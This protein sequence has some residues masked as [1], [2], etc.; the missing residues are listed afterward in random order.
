MDRRTWWIAARLA[1]A[2]AVVYVPG[3]A[4]RAS[5]PVASPPAASP[6]KRFPPAAAASLDV[7]VSDAAGKPVEGAF[8]MAVPSV[9]GYGRWGVLVADR[10]R[11]T[12]TSREGRA[13]LESLPAG[14][15]RVTVHARGYVEKSLPRV[16]AGPLVVRVERGGVITGSVRT[17]D[18]GRPIAGARVR[19]GGGPPLP[20]AWQESATR[21][22]STTDAQGR[23]RLEGIGRSPVGIVA[24]AAGFGSA[25]R[26]DVR[27]GD[28]VD[29]FLFPGA[30]LRGTVRDDAGRPVAAAQ[31]YAD[32]DR[33]R[34]QSQVET[35]DA[36]GAFVMAGIRPGEYV[37]VARGGSRAPG[38]AFV[39]VE[40]DAEASVSL[41]LSEGG[42]ATGQ[43]VDPDGRPLGGRVRLEVFEERGLSP[44]ASDAISS[45][46]GADGRFAL[47][48]LPLGTLGIGVSAPRHAARRV[49]VAIPARGR[50]VDLGRVTLETG[51]VIRGS[52]RDREGNPVLGARVSASSMGRVERSMG[53]AVT[54]S[55]AAFV[56]AGLRAGPHELIA[57]AAGFATAR[58]RGEPGGAPVTLVLQPGGEI[59]GRVVDA[60]GD[61]VDDADVESQATDDPRWGP[62]GT[63]GRSDEG[64]GRFAL[65]DV[66]AGTYVLQVRASGRGEASVTAVRVEPGRPT[67]VGT[68]VLNRGGVVQGVVVDV[69]GQGVVGATIQLEKDLEMQAGRYET[70]TAVS[71][72]F[73]LR[74]VPPGKIHVLA[75]HPAFA[76]VK[77]VVAD[78]DPEK[79]PVPVRIVLARGAR[80]EG[81]AQRRDGSPFTG[82]RITVSNFEL[83]PAMGWDP[84]AIAADGSFAVD[85]IA[86]GPATVNLMAFTPTSAMASGPTANALT[87]IATQDVELREGETT[88]ASF[89]LRDVIVAGHVTR[90]GQPASGVHVSLRPFQGGSMMS[91][92]PGAGRAVVAPSGPPPLNATTREDGS[93]ELLAFTPGRYRAQMITLATGQRHPWRELDLPDADRY[94]LE[95]EIADSIVSGVVVDRETGQPLADAQVSARKAGSRGQGSTATGPDGRFTIAVE[96][97]DYELF[98]QEE[99]HKRASVPVSVGAGG[100]SDVRVELERGL[101]LAGR[102]VDEAGRPQGDVELAVTSSE[103]SYAEGRSLPDGT[104]RIEGLDSVTYALAAGSGTRGFAVRTG[105]TPGGE[106][107]TLVLRSGGKLAIR[108]L[109]PDGRPVKGA[110]PDVHTWSGVAIELP[111]SGSSPTDASGACELSVPA[112]SLELTVAAE[113]L[114]GSVSVTVRTGESVPVEIRLHEVPKP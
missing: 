60:Q 57:A 95:L 21:V 46:A 100:L 68:V 74:G 104:F 42:Y 41:V 112:G 58:A 77:P 4:S 72:G 33:L 70:Q 26:G 83:G 106:P 85:H 87:G 40:P 108:V 12:L 64:D 76:A 65:R 69:D 19:V 49:E 97:G 50:A 35:S 34:S 84:A 16:S 47:G 13:R 38:I 92:G 52:V 8:V 102:V 37:V 53:E 15:W 88:T 7:L 81:R 5:T 32:S 110:W 67:N 24:R 80:L 20:Q 79:E 99:K 29:L 17:A 105:I 6:A 48:P 91:W 22:E 54:E 66:A 10:M 89:A 44:A 86:P 93:F 56:I 14:P 51:L 31:V 98:A 59:A 94:E 101:A 71:G 82:G 55:D 61:P 28:V 96:P 18:G 2:L 113:R 11:S 114:L 78:V 3:P 90:G 25:G 36:Q 111:Y 107:V 103:R 73:E 23:F 63:S 75:R 109:G 39:L 45:E 30:T 62:R 1:A 43:I 27:A 9:G